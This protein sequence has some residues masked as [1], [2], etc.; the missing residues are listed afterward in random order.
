M[1]LNFYSTFFAR[2]TKKS[3]SIAFNNKKA[4]E[5]FLHILQKIILVFI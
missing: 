3:L 5:Q 1:K 2:S 4:I